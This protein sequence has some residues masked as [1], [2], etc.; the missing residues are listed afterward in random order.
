[1]QE[2]RREKDSNERRKVGNKEGSKDRKK[3]K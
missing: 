1:M 3:K 2:Q